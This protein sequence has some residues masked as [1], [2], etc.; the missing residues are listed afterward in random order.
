[1]RK[2]ILSFLLSL[3]LFAHAQ[4][5][6]WATFGPTNTEYNAGFIVRAGYTI[7]GTMPMPIPA[8]IRYIA[9]FSPRGGGMIGVEGYKMFNRRWGLKAGWQFFHQGFHTAA[10]V[11][12]YQMTV[13]T[14][15]GESLSGFFT[16]TDVTNSEL[17]GMRFPVSATFRISPRW[18]VSLGPYLCTYFKKTFEGEVYENRAGQGYIRVGDPTGQ[19]VDLTRGSAS[20]DFHNNMRSWGGGVQLQFDWQALR[21]M[22]VFA[23]LDWTLSNALENDFTAVAFKMYPVYA[24]FGLAYRY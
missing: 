10:E 19:K 20:Y 23:Q 4:E 24:T 7:G 17:Y 16:G 5:D 8:E 14:E 6:R 3:P 22:N 11:K 1:M 2:Y 21:H 9:E 12:G 15:D 13:E 18:N